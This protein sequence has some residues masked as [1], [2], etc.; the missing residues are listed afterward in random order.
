M[1]PSDTIDS[2]REARRAAVIAVVR[3]IPPGVV[4]GYGEVARRAGLPRHARLVAKVLGTAD[5][6]SLPWHRVLRSDGRIALP[7]GSAGAR[8]QAR[9]LRA[10]GVD[11]VAGRV[12]QRPAVDT[13]D[14]ALWAPAE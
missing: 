7:A 9:R 13:L 5:D 4:L 6:P 8:E 2:T 3:A 14:G 11:V 1:R 10:E 12:R